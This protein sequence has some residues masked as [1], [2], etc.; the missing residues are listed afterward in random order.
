VIPTI[1]TFIYALLLNKYVTSLLYFYSFVK[2][3]LKLT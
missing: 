3:E 1:E 2:E